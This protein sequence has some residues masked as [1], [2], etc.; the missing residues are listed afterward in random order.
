M[1]TRKLDRI[2]N[3]YKTVSPKL[4]SVS[5]SSKCYWSLLQRMLNDKKIPVTPP[6]FHNDNF[7]SNFKEKSEFFNE[8]FSKQFSL[9]QNSSTIPSV[10]TPLTH[11]SFL[12]FQFTAKDIKSITNKLALNKAC[13]HDMV[14][15]CMI[16]LYGDSIYKQLEMIFNSCLNQQNGI[17][18]NTVPVY[19]RG[20]DQCVKNYR[21][22]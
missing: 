14:S 20:D 19:K 2:F 7:I 5:T 22:V 4:S 11:K 6:L 17:K 12:P 21:P 16:K 15:I 8:H 18:A 1:K 10:F 3:Y 9:I 13:G